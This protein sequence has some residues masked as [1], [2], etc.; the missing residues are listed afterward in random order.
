MRH[1]LFRFLL[2]LCLCLFGTAFLLKAQG[3]P[4][5]Q[6]TQAFTSATTGAPVNNGPTVSGGPQGAVAFRLV[7]YVQPGSGT[8]S[9]LSVELDGAPTSGGSYTALTPAA[10]GGS[11]SGATTNPVTS[12][13]QGQNVM[14]CDYYPFLHITVNTLT[15]ATGSPV[16]IVKVLGYAGTSASIFAIGAEPIGPA[17]G[18]LTGTYPNPGVERVNGGSIPDSSP[19]IGTNSSGQ[20]VASDTC[21]SSLVYY[22][23]NGSIASG[24]YIS[25]GSITGTVTQTCTLTFVGGNSTGTAT[26]PLTGTNT[27]ATDSALTITNVGSQF[28]TAPTSATLSNGTA[29][30]SGTA[31][32]TT[33]LDG[34]P[35]DISGDYPMLPA[36]YNPKTTMTFAM[37]TGSG[38]SNIQSFATAAG[39]PGLAFIPAGSYYCHIHTSRT[40]GFTGTAVFQCLFEEVTSAG[41]FVAN[42]G[43]TTQTANIGLTEAEYIVAYNDPNVYTMA[44]VADR[45]VAVLQ[46]VQTSVGASGTLDVYVGGEADT[47]IQLPASTTQYSID[48]VPF[49]TGFT[50]TAGVGLLYTTGGSPNPCWSITNLTDDGTEIYTVN[51]KFGIGIATPQGPLQVNEGT[52]LDIVLSAVGGQTTIQATNDAAGAYVPLKLRA[53]AFSAIG[54]NFMLGT[55]TDDGT[56]SVLQTNGIMDSGGYISHGSFPSITGCGTISAYAGG[57]TA[58]VFTTTTTGTCAASFT[59]PTAPN[60]WVCVVQDITKHVATNILIQTG[61]TVSSCAVTGTTAASD[62]LTFLA[63]GY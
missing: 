3:T 11:G 61:S 49:C 14:C 51:R 5:L 23:Q 28:T 62:V 12:F 53:S 47:H 41:V 20:I 30:C 54:G 36:P 8:V 45:V 6:F 33:V 34:G 4:S 32:V 9:A 21:G 56:G 40:N 38:T 52:N 18:D 15:V 27:I 58:G 44:N 43:T 7:Y 2:S 35:S 26:V 13:P 31:T 17:G 1:T 10:G 42:I 16:L 46:L 48:G 24:Q 55:A 39:A 50:P 63:I 25:G 37:G 57:P 29:T 19:C 60:G 59:M 22:M